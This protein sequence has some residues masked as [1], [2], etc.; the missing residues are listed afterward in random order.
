MAW[1]RAEAGGL[2]LF[3]RLTPRGG[4]DAIDG[5][6]PLA[7]GREVLA[8]RVRVPPE[9]G[10]ANTALTALIAKAFDVP[11]SAVALAAGATARIKQV[12]VS[13]DAAVL[14]AVADSLNAGKKG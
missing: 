2:A 8:V 6:T 7:D 13:G 3:V 14:A 4:R 1:Y 5:V 9:D 12:R 11:R 10:A